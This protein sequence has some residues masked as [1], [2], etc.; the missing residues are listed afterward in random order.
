MLAC[1]Y[2]KGN[3]GF[4]SRCVLY[5]PLWLSWVWNC[6][7]WEFLVSCLHAGG[8]LKQKLLMHVNL[9]CCHCMMG[10]L[11]DVA[12]S[13]VTL[14]HLQSATSVAKPATNSNICC[15]TCYKQQHLLQNLLQI[16]TSVAKPATYQQ[17]YACSTSNRCPTMPSYNTEQLSPT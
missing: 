16:A 2:C 6:Q 13:K 15:K 7:R 9:R 11:G 1:I 14:Q 8:I 3:K 10:Q 4:W 5:G 17:H 12:R